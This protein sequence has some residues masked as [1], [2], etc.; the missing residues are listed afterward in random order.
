M[1]I[2][3]FLYIFAL[4]KCDFVS[5]YFA[6]FTNI[7]LKSPQQKQ[8]NVSAISMRFPIANLLRKITIHLTENISSP[9]PRNRKKSV[10]SKNVTENHMIYIFQ[11]EF[12][13]FSCCILFSLFAIVYYSTH[14]IYSFRNKLQNTFSCWFRLDSSSCFLFI[15]FCY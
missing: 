8:R 10:L 2:Y 4:R 12:L 9:F 3:I 14:G 11:K 13:I 15:Y 5:W 6:Y 7:I 1:N